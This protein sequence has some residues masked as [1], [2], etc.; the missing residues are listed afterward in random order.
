MVEKREKFD[1]MELPARDE[2]SG[3]NGVLDVI[4]MCRQVTEVDYFLVATG[5][6]FYSV[7]S[8]VPGDGD[9]R[10]KSKNRTSFRGKIFHSIEGTKNT[11]QG[12]FGSQMGEKFDGCGTARKG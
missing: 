3:K 2:G 10:N 8:P 9:A 11:G 4:I 5:I 1:G 12:L 6:Q 7:L